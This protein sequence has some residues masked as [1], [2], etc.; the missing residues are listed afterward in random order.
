MYDV[1]TIFAGFIFLYSVVAGGLTRTPFSGAIVFCA[2]GWL[3]GPLALGLF[4]LEVDAEGIRLLAELT[5]A[6]VLFADAA[7]VDLNVLRRAIGLPN[8]LLLLALPLIIVLGFGAGVVLL[9]ELTLLEAA[10]VATMLAPTDAALGSAVVSD[11]RVPSKIRQALSV[12]SG[13]NDGICVPILFLFLALAT[14]SQH[15]AS[16]AE[17]ALVL[18][19]EEIG[20]GAAVGI[21]VTFLGAHLLRV[22][23]DRGWV[24]ET[25]RQLPVISLAVGSF[26]AAQLI[27]GSGFIAAFVGGLLFG[28][29]A[30]DRKHVLL[31]A[32]EGAGET[33]ALVTWV[34][35]GAVI[36]GHTIDR[37][38]WE[39]V[40]YA[41][42]SLTVIRMLPVFLVLV[43]TG[44]SVGEKLFIGWFG[45]RGMASIVF[46]VIVL[47]ADL[48]GG[49][50]LRQTVL[51]TVV[52][53]ILA[54][55]L[56][57]NPLIAA[58]AAR[59]SGRTVE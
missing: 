17:L 59:V 34:V 35:F 45:P 7:K 58:L 38:I 19:A 31:L 43:G 39:A 47:Q 46:A 29:L 41:L 8:R 4:D 49:E 1:L 32:A 30:K 26:A 21:G 40:V 33:V 25:W 54:H 53:S 13:L 44:L 15:E 48:P 5:L 16:G 42:L 51:Y 27:G 23:R 36:V 3:I 9:E 11:E 10:L 52:F 20:I 55:G 12:E 24:T 22:C 37:I 57:A 50:I 28:A 14:Q 6:L 18:V 56:S 2:F